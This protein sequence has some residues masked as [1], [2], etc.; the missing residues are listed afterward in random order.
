M[1]EELPETD[2]EWKEKL[3]EQQ[4]RILR[5]KDTE[6][7]FSGDLLEVNDEG[8]FRCAGCGQALFDSDT[9]FDSESGWPS[10]WDAIDGS[11]ELENDS[12]MSMNR[13]E[14][15]CSNCG[16]HLGHVFN[17]G[18]SNKTGKRFCINSAALKFEED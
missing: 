14:V 9:K 3:S 7:R 6:S 13:T 5:E 18:P 1:S 2:E 16:G 10:F 12:S 11:V 17:D 4:Y 8:V 15:I